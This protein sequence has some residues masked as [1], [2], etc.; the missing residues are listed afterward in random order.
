[1]K[2]AKKEAGLCLHD[3]CGSKAIA[4]PV[5]EYCEKHRSEDPHIRPRKE[6]KRPLSN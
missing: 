2:A 6:K 1:M 3:G 4:P 5:V